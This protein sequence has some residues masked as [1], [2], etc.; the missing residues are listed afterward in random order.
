MEVNPEGKTG[1]NGLIHINVCEE[2]VWINYKLKFTL[3]VS[4]SL[5]K[6]FSLTL[7]L[8]SD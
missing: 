6:K 4:S 1:E 7:G 5:Q 8:V 3:I 2:V